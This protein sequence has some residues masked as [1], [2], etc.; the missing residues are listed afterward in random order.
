[1]KLKIKNVVTAGVLSTAMSLSVL[2]TATAA[3]WGYEGE[4]GPESWHLIHGNELCGSG[5][6]QSPIDIN[7][8]LTASAKRGDLETDYDS[9][10]L[11]VENNG[12]TIQV[13]MAHGTWQ[14]HKDA[15]RQILS[16]SVPLPCIK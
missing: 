11:N 7:P 13:N 6:Q 12:H 5:T 2:S 10:A 16:A 1:M 4:Y 8:S 9:V 14:H 15:N 3:E